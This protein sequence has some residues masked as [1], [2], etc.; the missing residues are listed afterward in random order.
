MMLYNYRNGYAILSYMEYPIILVQE[1]VLIYFVMYYKEMIGTKS[2]VG[3][4][5]YFSLTG[6]FLFSI[7]PRE[8]LTFL[9]VNNIYLNQTVKC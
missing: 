2:V 8:I 3:A 7:L 1:L 4:G 6:G 5:I 9:V